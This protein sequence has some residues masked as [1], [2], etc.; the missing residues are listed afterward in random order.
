M[1]ELA[2]LVRFFLVVPPVPSM[3]TGTFGI[4]TLAAAAAIVGDTNRAAGALVPVLL[5]QSLAASS[6]FALPARRGHY[7][8][9][10]TRGKNRTLIAIV[11]WATSIAPGLA[12]WL[13]LATLE[14]ILSGGGHASLLATGTC[15]AVFLV[16]TLPWAAT[17]ALPRFSGGIAWML[18]VVTAAT[19]FPTG[20]VGQWPA[21]STRIEDLALS[22]WSFLVYPAGAIG[23][24][25]AR[26]ETT[27][28]VP[29]VVLAV[30]SMVT[31]C[32]WVSRAEFPLEASQ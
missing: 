7:D 29:A 15:A 4:V 9:L 11:H 30:A 10:L 26:Q 1:R 24:H 21:H 18:V 20:V 23:H 17:I 5:L 27:A 25:L 13:V 14:L 3:M 31:A 6:G 2:F 19:A 28:T 22:A 16:S 8:L 12:S 32:R